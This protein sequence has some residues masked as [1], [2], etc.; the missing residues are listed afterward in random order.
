MPLP[1]LVLLTLSLAFICLCATGCLM[2]RTVTEGDEV[3]A[4][5]YVV[6]APLIAP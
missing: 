6:K 1:R 2:R 3:V 5:G 4:Q